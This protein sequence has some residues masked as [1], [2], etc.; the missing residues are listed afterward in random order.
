MPADRVDRALKLHPVDSTCAAR[1][2]YDENAREA[3]VEFHESG[4]YAYEGVPPEVYAEFERRL[5]GTFV[6]TVLK[7]RYSARKL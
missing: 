1:I 6:N 5:Q 2:G 3:Y 4:L 7:P